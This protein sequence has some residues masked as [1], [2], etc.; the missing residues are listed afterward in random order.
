MR[1]RYKYPAN[2]VQYVL[3]RDLLPHPNNWRTHPPEQLK[4]V[5]QIVD[6]LG[7]VDAVKVVEL[8]PGKFQ[9]VD[10]HARVEVLPDEQ[11]PVLVLDLTPDE[12][13]Q[14]LATFD[15]LGA[16]AGRDPQKLAGLLTDLK[17]FGD[18][19]AGVVWPD[20]VID[21]LMSANWTPPAVAT[22]PTKTA[23]APEP[24]PPGDDHPHPAG[25]TGFLIALTD[26]ERD[27]WLEVV[28]RVR[29]QKPFS[30][31]GEVL[32]DLCALFDLHEAATS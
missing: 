8:G 16:M 18:T 14:L 7:F 3:G 27:V 32:V 22:M 15:P 21:P 10:G 23:P 20:Y 2:P 30:T 6:T 29:L 5:K 13:K 19:L 9:I 26:A 25:P 12:T 28:R 31:E 4:A 17:G 24:T 11:I 1:V